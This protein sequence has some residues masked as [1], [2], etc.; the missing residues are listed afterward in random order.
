MVSQTQKSYFFKI[1]LVS[2]FAFQLVMPLFFILNIYLVK[3]DQQNLIKT[4]RLVEQLIISQKDIK[5]VIQVD[6]HEIWYHHQMYDIATVTYK[7]GNYIFE[8]VKDERETN[9]AESENHQIN[10]DLLALQLKVW[11]AINSTISPFQLSM[12]P[13]MADCPEISTMVQFTYQINS[14]QVPSPPPD[15]CA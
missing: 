5:S 11:D 13:S 3:L 15:F 14:Q 12:N 2:I 7:A 10:K 4:N 8:V 9:L 6:D 1:V